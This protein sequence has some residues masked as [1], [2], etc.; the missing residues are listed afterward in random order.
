MDDGDNRLEQVRQAFYERLSAKNIRALWTVL[1]DLVTAEPRHEMQACH[2][3]YADVRRHLMEAGDLITAKEAERR[4]LILENPAWPGESRLTP[5]LYAAIQ[6]ILPGD[7][8]PAHRHTQSALRFVLEGAGAFT[9]V[10]G[11][12]THM[13]RG[14]F[15]ITPNWT[16]HDHGNETDAPMIWLDGL[17]IPLVYFMN[18][19]FAEHND[20]ERQ[21]ITKPEGDA[22]ARFG[23]GLLPVDYEAGAFSTSPIFNYTYEKSRETL[24]RLRHAGRFDPCH[25]VKQKYVHPGTGDYAM[26]TIATFLQ[27]LP[28]G[29]ETA[30]YR[31]TDATVFVVV[32]GS[33]HSI[34]GGE[35]FDWGENDLFVVPTWREVTHHPAEDAVLFSYS[36]RGVQEKLGLWRE[37]RGAPAS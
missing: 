12:T 37:A 32:E 33:G 26:P 28:K 19:S 20:D 10:D 2:W 11:E 9:A 6:L 36:D 21:E 23:S 27:L 17:D 25:G 31:S 35:R 4:A 30:P 5:T 22:P 13:Q 8:A 16:W 15:V 14:D 24:E 3:R 29:L 34:I 18:V 1:G 7:V